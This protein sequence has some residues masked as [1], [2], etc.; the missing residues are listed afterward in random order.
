MPP[1]P[2]VHQSLGGEGD[3]FEYALPLEAGE[4]HPAHLALFDPWHFSLLGKSTEE[5]RAQ[6]RD[7]WTRLVF[8]SNQRF[9]ASL[10]DR[11]PDAFLINGNKIWLS[12]GCADDS[13][14]VICIR[15][16]KVLSD[17]SRRTIE[18]F[19]VPSLAEF[20]SHFGDLRESKWINVNAILDDRTPLD[21]RTAEMGD[22]GEWSAAL[23]VY[24]ICSGNLMLM[25]RGGAVALWDH[26]FGWGG[27]TPEE[28][29]TP[30]A[31]SFEEYLEAYTS[32]LAASDSKRCT[33][34]FY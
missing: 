20:L 33:T 14:N 10:S 25:R 22:L 27:G 30:V 29:I 5:V 2:I 32:Y 16:P 24:Y 15:A 34:P 31:E 3:T 28:I 18:A 26:E 21:P 8:P 7:R 19:G 9:A 23:P 4:I 6:L 11:I 17:T 13:E 1:K 12:L